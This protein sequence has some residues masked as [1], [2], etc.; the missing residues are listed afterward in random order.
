MKTIHLNFDGYW[1]EAGAHNVPVG[2]GVYCVYACTYNVATD[3]VAIRD[4]LYVGES[5]DVRGRLVNHERLSGWKRQLRSGEVLC[6][7]V[8]KVAPSDRLNAEAALIHRHKPPCNTEYIT[9][10][11]FGVTMMHTSGMNALLEAVFAVRTKW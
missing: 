8:A 2:S 5:C 9:R 3:C 1:L 4:L 11:P 6:Y 7:S 10:F